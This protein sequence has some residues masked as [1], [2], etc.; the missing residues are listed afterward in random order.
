MTEEFQLKAEEK[1]LLLEIARNTLE[2]YARTGKKPPLP[3][4]DQLSQNL[5]ASCGAFVTLHK[6]GQLRG[7]IGIFE[8]HGTL[9]ETVSEMAICAGWKDPRF[10]PLEEEELKD[11][12]I[13][14][15]VL[16]PLQPARPEDIQVGKHG[17]YITKG[18]YRGVLLPQVATEYG[19][20]RETFLEHTCLKA[21]L[22]SDAWK[23]PDTR[24]EIFSAIV[25]SEK[26]L[27]A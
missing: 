27:N 20:D 16:S 8:G 4:K 12:E 5:K 26:D 17:I 25:F 11:L 7:C 10:P 2:S 18:F 14:I 23:D 21:G 15:S 9:A 1:R 24:I 19:W 22:P 6:D 13:E 3:K